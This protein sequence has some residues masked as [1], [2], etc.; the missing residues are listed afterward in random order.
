MFFLPR[1]RLCAAVFPQR[2]TG[3]TLEWN[4]CAAYTEDGGDPHTGGV[5]LW[6]GRN[7]ARDSSEFLFVMDT[8]QAASQT[9]IIKKSWIFENGLAMVLSRYPGQMTQS[10]LPHDNDTNLQNPDRP[11]PPRHFRWSLQYPLAFPSV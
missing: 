1:T 8:L 4:A 9:W 10:H 11:W 5:Q 2:R 3:R 6:G 7:A